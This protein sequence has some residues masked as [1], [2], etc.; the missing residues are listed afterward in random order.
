[1]AH[2]LYTTLDN[3][4][5]MQIEY[6]TVCMCMLFFV[7]HIVNRVLLFYIFVVLGDIVFGHMCMIPNPCSLHL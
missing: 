3:N 4:I 7:L 6:Y 1:M 5:Q 2:H